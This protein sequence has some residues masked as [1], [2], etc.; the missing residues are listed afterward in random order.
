MFLNEL[1]ESVRRRLDLL[2]EI[3]DRG[4]DHAVSEVARTEMPSLVAAV[5]A[6]MAEHEPD[7]T[8]QCPA[9]SR[10]LRRWQRLW[11]QPKSPCRV[12]LAARWALLDEQVGAA[13]ER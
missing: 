10:I 8:G 7:E 13:G 5:R 3:A 6:L 11:R 9:C 2:A 4:D 12:Y 1:N